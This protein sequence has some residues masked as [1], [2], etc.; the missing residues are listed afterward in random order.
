MAKSKKKITIMT[1]AEVA[2][3][4][5]K[6]R[7]RKIKQE[8]NQNAQYKGKVFEDK[9]RKAQKRLQDQEDREAKRGEGRE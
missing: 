2:E 7:K 9:K 8:M 1:A 4:K 6:A 3:Q 5:R